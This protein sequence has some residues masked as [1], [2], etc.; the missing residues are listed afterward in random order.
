MNAVSQ[1][2]GLTRVLDGVF[3]SDQTNVV[4]SVDRSMVEA[5]MWKNLV[6]LVDSRWIAAVSSRALVTKLQ[7]MIA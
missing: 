3:Q 5:L 2:Q 4:L 7:V 6:D 1:S